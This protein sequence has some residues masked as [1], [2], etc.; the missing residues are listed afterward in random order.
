ML[1]SWKLR[2]FQ[3]VGNK[4]TTEAEVKWGC[5]NY[6]GAAVQSEDGKFKS[7]LER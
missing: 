2:G 7:D 1:I 4:G 5:W 6:I 3:P